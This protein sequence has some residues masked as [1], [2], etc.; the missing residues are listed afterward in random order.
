MESALTKA[1]R[2]FTI[3][4]VSVA[5]LCAALGA[6]GTYAYAEYQLKQTITAAQIGQ[7]VAGN[8]EVSAYL[9]SQAPS[10]AHFE[11]I[12]RIIQRQDQTHLTASLPIV[13]GL[14]FVLS[15]LAG[16]WLSRELLV[17]VKQSY[18]SQRRFMQDAAHELRNPLAA[19]N[20]IVQQA[21]NHPPKP[22]ELP[23]VLA[24]VSRQASQ[25]STITTELLLLE[26]QEYPG[27]Q[28]VNISDLLADVLEELQFIAITKRVKLLSRNT[29]EVV[30][31]INPQ[32][33]VHMAKNVIENAIKYSPPDAPAIEVALSKRPSGWALVIRDHG[34][35]IPATDI[36]NLTQRFY[37]GH[38]ASH[39]GGTG[40]G[41]AIVAKY[42]QLYH[43]TMN[44]TSAVG[45]GTTVTLE[46]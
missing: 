38:N 1:R 15:G 3:V 36:P 8:S 22:P 4:T 28:T 9:A 5:F 32:H 46:I 29:E 18:D 13:L 24:A 44:I 10:H 42:V 35:G 6:I 2:Q 23:S 19:M 39:T 11:T 26:H 41:M 31:E 20:S 33:F 43:G 16:W 25:L 45:S 30:A 12:A 34:I 21:Q 27:T 40:L 7:L 17:P 14:V 37:R